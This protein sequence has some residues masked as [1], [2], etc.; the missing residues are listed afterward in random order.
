MPTEACIRTRQ[1]ALLVPDC[2]MQD[3]SHQ[4][5]CCNCDHRDKP[6]CDIMGHDEYDN[7]VH[8]PGVLFYCINS[9]TD[10]GI[11]V[12]CYLL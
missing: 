2:V 4:K 5:R 8:I 3:G 6:I 11:L 12:C 1:R 7:W 10:T 9:H